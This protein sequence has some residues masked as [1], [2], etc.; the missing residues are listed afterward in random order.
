MF[1]VY[2]VLAKLAK[3]A[4]IGIRR[5]MEDDFKIPEQPNLPSVKESFTDTSPY[6]GDEGKIEDNKELISKGSQLTLNEEDFSEYELDNLEKKVAVTELSDCDLYLKNLHTGF[7]YVNSINSLIK[8][9]GAG[10]QVHKHRRSVIE[11]LKDGGN[12]KAA[13]TFDNNGNIIPKS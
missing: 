7:K 6:E 13:F 1:I 4:L 11:K 3:L 9:V 8:I 12:G 2:P 5:K 10:I